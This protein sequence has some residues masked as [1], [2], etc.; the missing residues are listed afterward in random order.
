LIASYWATPTIGDWQNGVADFDK[1]GIVNALDYS[2]I[3]TNY[4]K[5]SPQIISE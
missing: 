5:E 4:F 3:S 2:L 1:N